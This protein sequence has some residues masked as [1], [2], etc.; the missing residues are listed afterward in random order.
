MKKKTPKPKRAKLIADG[1]FYQFVPLKEL[2]AR[3]QVP[4]MRRIK[5]NEPSISYETVWNFMLVFNLMRVTKS[6]AEYKQVDCLKIEE[7]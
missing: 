3:L 6:Y 1:G 2:V 7:R 4:V 5:L